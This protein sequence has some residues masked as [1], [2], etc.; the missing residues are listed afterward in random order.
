[1]HNFVSNRFNTMSIT[2][3]VIFRLIFKLILS[4]GYTHKKI[5]SWYFFTMSF[6]SEKQTY[7]IGYFDVVYNSL[8]RGFY[9]RS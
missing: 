7:E 5:K 3:I 2:K 4:I 1:M 6:M 9:R 8:Y